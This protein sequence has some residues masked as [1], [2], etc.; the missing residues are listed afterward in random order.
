[1]SWNK[2]TSYVLVFIA[3]MVPT[4]GSSAQDTL[5]AGQIFVRSQAVLDEPRG[6][7]LDIPGHRERVDVARDL[8]VHTCK[9]GIWN[10]DERFSA[11]EF[12]G[13]VLRMPE[14]DQCVVGRG[15]HADSPVG[16]MHC[17]G[18]PA[19]Q[20]RFTGQRL[21][22]KM[23]D[24]LCLTIGSESSELTPGGRRLPSRHV[25]RSVGLAACSDDAADRQ[26]W[27]VESPDG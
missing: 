22:P 21:M 24:K 6:L 23:Y 17:D 7:C 14:Y 10:L 4:V 13:G 8:V 15:M 16:L 2:I 11:A 3:F 5:A 18:S 19:Q 20:W 9:R 1:M 25:A 12:E 27:I 26:R